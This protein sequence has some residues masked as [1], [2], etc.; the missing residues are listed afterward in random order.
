MKSVTSTTT[1]GVSVE[2]LTKTIQ[3]VK[4]QPEIAKFKF[5]VSNCWL[6]GAHNR[7]T[8]NGFRGAMQ[9][10]EHTSKFAMDAGEHQVL[11]GRDEGANPVEFL[12]HALAA[13]VTTSTVYHAAAQGI[14]IEAIESK[15]EGELDLRGFLGLD[16]SVRNGY[17]RIRMTMKIK[18]SASD[19]QW[20]R[21]I[22]LGPDFS[23]VFDSVT[24]GVPVDIAAERM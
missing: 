20:A 7:S 11:L 1:N 24:R 17:E 3:A 22:T 15:I 10:L 8:V 21:L 16:P 18:T 19:R 12:L 14:E 5:N 13:C 4:E 2:D 23:P 9:D 6:G